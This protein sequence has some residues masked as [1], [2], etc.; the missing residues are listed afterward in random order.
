MIEALH[1]SDAILSRYYFPKGVKLPSGKG[2]IDAPEIHKPIDPVLTGLAQLGTLKLQCRRSLV[3]LMNRKNQFILA[4]ATRTLSLRSGV[5]ENEDDRIFMG[6]RRLEY[7]WPASYQS[8]KHFCSAPDNR[9]HEERANLSANSDHYV[10]K[11]VGAEGAYKGSNYKNYVEHWPYIN[12]YAGVPLRTK[13]GYVLGTYCIVDDAP[14]EGGLS[15]QDLDCME[16]IAASIM[17]HLEFVRTRHDF[18]KADYLVKGL[19]LFAEGRPSLRDWWMRNPDNANNSRALSIAERLKDLKNRADDEFGEATVPDPIPIVI[20]TSSPATSPHGRTTFNA[21]IPSAASVSDPS[22]LSTGTEGVSKSPSDTPGSVTSDDVDDSNAGSLHA[23]FSRASNLIREAMQLEGVVFLDASWNRTSKLKFKDSTF[24][25]NENVV[26]APS[27]SDEELEDKSHH[28]YHEND[29]R[30]TPKSSHL[31]NETV[32]SQSQATVR[33]CSVLGSSIRKRAAAKG[34]S[35]P[36][37][38]GLREKS[39]CRLLKKYPN[40][41]IFA[42]DQNI[43]T[44]STEGSEDETAQS[45]SEVSYDSPSESSF[46]LPSYKRQKR[47]VRDIAELFPD[48]RSIAFYPIYDSQ[49]RRWCAAILAWTTKH[50]RILH[51]DDLMYFAT[52]GNNILSDI[53]RLEAIFADQVKSTFISSISHEFRSPLHGILGSAELLKE[54]S[55]G[56]TQDNLIRMTEICGRTLLDTMDHLLDFAKINNFTS[57]KKG[58]RVRKELSESAIGETS[59]VN[60]RE[61]LED[62]VEAVFAS[63]TY[64]K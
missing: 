64:S 26:T 56:A 20:T 27:S 55:T 16:D 51:S 15:K 52:F 59:E 9:I 63:H 17:D 25:E 57:T 14:R 22:V 38:H 32:S 41:H 62:V 33:T 49:A 7:T 11:N 19:G 48:A 43:D 2:P 42:V 10:L 61:L 24:H 39:L 12:F 46:S 40:G 21:T 31:E 53:W 50:T 34:Q 47:T 5:P 54:T 8:M 30:E 58:S 37:V 4:E 44:V 1:W 29:P 23:M 36:S 35:N 6:P 45:T 28:P 13:S 18:S 60:L 3:S